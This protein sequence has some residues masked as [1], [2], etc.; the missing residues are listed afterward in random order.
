MRIAIGT[1]IV[2][3]LI[4]I[5][6]LRIVPRNLYTVLWQNES[7]EVD[8][9]SYILFWNEDFKKP[10]KLSE[11]VERKLVNIVTDATIVRANNKAQ[12]QGLQIGKSG[13]YYIVLKGANF[14]ITENGYVKVGETLYKMSPIEFQLLWDILVE[15]TIMLI[16]S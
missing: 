9:P 2:V 3:L 13:Y 10:Y 12:R 15:E 14:S 11:D 4:I 7:N 5:I 1:V 8:L 6:A 16:N